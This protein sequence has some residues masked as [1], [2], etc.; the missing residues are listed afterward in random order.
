MRGETY[1][2]PARTTY[3]ALGGQP[4]LTVAEYS[5]LAEQLTPLFIEEVVCPVHLAA[6]S[7]WAAAQAAAAGEVERAA[8][9]HREVRA[10]L[11]DAL[12]NAG[13]L[14]FD[15]QLQEIAA[16]DAEPGDA[17]D[18]RGVR[19][20]LRDRLSMRQWNAWRANDIP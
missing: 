15:E 20:R 18:E 16:E 14:T 5:R 7:L 1:S 12:W 11:Y 8:A 3:E 13:L 6:K 4:P 17:H 9:S 19:V 2:G 10:R